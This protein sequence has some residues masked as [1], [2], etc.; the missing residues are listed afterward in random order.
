MRQGPSSGMVG[1]RSVIVRR[2]GSISYVPIGSPVSVIETRPAFRMNS[3]PARSAGG[4]LVKSSH[5]RPSIASVIVNYPMLTRRL[6][7]SEHQSARCADGTVLGCSMSSGHERWTETL[8]IERQDGNQAPVFVAKRIGALALAG[9]AAGVGR[10]KQ[11]PARLD[12]LR[13]PRNFG[14]LGWTR[15]RRAYGSSGESSGTHTRKLNA[16]TRR[17][18]G[19]PSQLPVSG[20]PTFDVR[21]RLTVRQKQPLTLETYRSGQ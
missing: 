8:A 9:D 16:L 18:R 3:L 6:I 10:F 20:R 7:V 19:R 5:Q 17:R 13:N 2:P 1:M 21:Q 12:Q 15:P 14:R 4:R 11:I